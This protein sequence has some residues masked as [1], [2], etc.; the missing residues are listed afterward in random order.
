MA[1]HRT[2][3]RS[4]HYSVGSAVASIALLAGIPIPLLARD[5]D[6]RVPT[7]RARAPVYSIYGPHDRDE[8]APATAPK[9]VE[10]F[11]EAVTAAYQ[12]YPELL[13]LRASVRNADNGYA[14]ARSDF[15]PHLSVEVRHSYQ[16]DR[17][18]VA[19]GI[20]VG[21]QGF[22]STGSLILNQPLLTFGRNHANEA[23]ALAQI[24]FARDSL[25]L[26]ESELLQAVVAAYIGV[27]RDT[28]ILD[29]SQE[30]LRLLE[31]QLT[32]NTARFGKREITATDLEQVATRVEFGRAQLLAAQGQLSASRAQFLQYTGTLPGP[33]L[34]P[35]KELNVPVAGL[36][37]ALALAEAAGP[38]IRAAQSREKISRAL[39]AAARADVL[40]R[41][42][43]EA[44]GSYGAVSPYNNQLVGS[45]LRASVV[46]RLQLWDSGERTAKIR[47]AQEANQADWRLIDLAAR[48]TR[49]QVA[50][51]W[52]QWQAARRSVSHYQ[53]AIQ[54]AQRAFD[55]AVIQERAG[56]RTTLDVL[57]L[58][59][60]L[61][62]V[63][64]SYVQTVATDYIARASLL[65]A[66]GEMEAPRLVPTVKP[67][68][69]SEHFRAVARRGDL[70]L[71]TDALSGIDA[72]FN[73]DLSSDRP[74]RDQSVRI[75]IE[76]IF[77]DTPSPP[78]K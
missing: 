49:Q 46:G 1:R 40:P 5:I 68:D 71:L 74:I 62:A 20:F 41:V 31:R 19:K 39:L 6:E 15:G 24:A 12:A 18:E 75:A 70:P 54:A 73:A 2:R 3:R 38:T 21:D 63:R 64:T 13:S 72:V 77:P 36:D 4:R 52:D 60:D 27:I 59:R 48:E 78:D 28:A 61:L 35:P 17:S 30:N 51:A 14:S 25:R 53:E 22:S 37:Q 33:A 42:D 56:F 47:E 50:T 45:D 8:N 29:I 67:Y 7:A 43:L 69:P 55:G 16:R 65:A 34:A 76:P 10:T 11:A 32:E 26:R 44:S 9:A 57:D 23:N 58:A 66:M